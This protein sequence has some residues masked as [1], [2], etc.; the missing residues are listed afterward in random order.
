MPRVSIS[1]C[2]NGGE[3]VGQTQLVEQSQR[4]GV[5][6]VAAEV[7]QEVGVLLHHR[8]VDAGAGE[9]Q[10]EHHARRTAAG[11]DA[12]GVHCPAGVGPVGGHVAHLR[13]A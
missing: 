8:H 4:A 2:G 12:G 13:I 6:R 1:R 9:Q 3:L 10:P 11:D 7:A 5:H